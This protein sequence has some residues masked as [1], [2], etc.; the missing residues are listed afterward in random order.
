MDTHAVHIISYLNGY[1]HIGEGNGNPLQCSCLENP[2]D[3]GA[4]WA[5]IYGVAQS[6][7]RLTWLRAEWLPLFTQIFNELWHYAKYFINNSHAIWYFMFSSIFFFSWK[8]T[9]LLYFTFLVWC[10]Y[11]LYF[12][13]SQPLFSALT[14]SSS[15]FNTSWSFKFYNTWFLMDKVHFSYIFST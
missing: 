6:R 12:Y 3:R 11:H 7:T 8:H 4:W 1:P 5:A 15:I 2:R 10:P 14:T 9:V 13:S